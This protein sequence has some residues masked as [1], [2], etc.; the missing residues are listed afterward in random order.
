MHS[1]LNSKKEK[2]YLWFMVFLK[3]CFFLFPKL[4]KGLKD[5]QYFK[6][7]K[8]HI[9]LQWLCRYTFHTMKTFKDIVKLFQILTHN[10]YSLKIYII[11]INKNLISLLLCQSNKNLPTLTSNKRAVFVQNHH[12]PNII[13]IL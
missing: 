12:Q 4:N 3:V 5:L 10:H 8:R 11:K 1:I 9:K 2:A 6:L 7:F 13:L